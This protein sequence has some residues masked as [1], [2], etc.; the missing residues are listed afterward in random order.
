ML[1]LF[2][3]KGY[4]VFI[5]IPILLYYATFETRIF[6]SS[7]NFFRSLLRNV[8]RATNLCGIIVTLGGKLKYQNI[9]RILVLQSVDE[10]DSRF[11]PGNLAIRSN[12]TF[13]G[14]IWTRLTAGRIFLALVYFE[15]II[16]HNFTLSSIFCFLNYNF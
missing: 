5:F 2:L 14:Q 3:I 10:I 7:R 15:I 9:N 6:N 11:N 1:F 8:Q 13:S 4:F 16:T 12:H